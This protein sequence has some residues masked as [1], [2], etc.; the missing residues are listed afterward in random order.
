MVSVLA[1][2]QGGASSGVPNNGVIRFAEFPGSVPNWIMP[3][4]DLGHTGSPNTE[5]LSYLMWRPL[6]WRGAGSQP[7][8]DESLSLAETPVFSDGNTTVTVKLKNYQWSD[9]QPVTSRDVEFWWNLI[10]ADKAQWSNYVPG[11]LPD[12]VSSFEVVD[13]ATFRLH[14]KQPTSPAWFGSDQLWLLTPMPQ[15]VW[16][17]ASANGQVS[18]LDRTPAGA[19]AVFNFLINESKQLSQYSTD[20]LWKVVDGPWTLKSYDTEGH[21]AFVPNPKYSGPVKPAIKEF[22][23]VPFENGAAEFNSLIAGDV[24]YG[25]LPFTNLGQRSRIEGQGYHFSAWNLW[26]INYIAV[27]YNQPTTGPIVSQQYVRQALESMVDQKSIVQAVFQGQG[28]QNFSPIALTPPNPYT[29]IQQNPNPYNPSRAVSL[30]RSHGWDVQPNGT[31]TCT[32]AGTGANQCGDGIPAGAKMSFNLTVNSGN[33]PVSREMQVLKSEFSKDAGVQLNVTGQPFT[34]LISN[35]FTSCTK[36]QP[37]TCPWQMTDWG[38][39]SD[40]QAYPTGEQILSSNGSQNA[41]HYSDPKADQLINA[42]H[43]GGTFDLNAYERYVADQVPVIWVPNLTIQLSMIRNSISG[44]DEQNAY[45]G[46][47]P[48]AWRIHS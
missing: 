39:G 22:D 42:T 20:P 31:T 8:I 33:E 23:E 27:N 2:C 36:Q 25:Y 29:T 3:I 21:I 43:L 34:T 17:K 5:Q 24:D 45:F 19:L 11:D 16:D 48:E 28:Y 47:T 18:D 38:G 10:Q 46:I 40:L 9:G 44:A 35:V 32:N 41:G 15:H 12:N 37:Q 4:T 26:T 13:P 14:L 30:L 6:Y 7:Q 1:A